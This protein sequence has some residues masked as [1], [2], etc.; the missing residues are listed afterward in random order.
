MK[1]LITSMVF[2]SFSA[3]AHNL[4]TGSYVEMQDKLA[5]DD[6]QGAMKIQKQICEKELDEKHKKEYQD[7]GKKF[8][9]IKDIR[10]SFK[11][12]SEFYIKHGDTKEIDGL[13]VAYCP[14]AK[15]KWI[16]KKGSIRNP[17]YG[18]TML[19]CGGEVDK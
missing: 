13:L 4:K 12:L 17:Y 7:C 11:S 18:K 5:S 10:E 8:K 14:M 3:F 6:F 2:L 9:D 19:D 15:A 1:F 16:Q